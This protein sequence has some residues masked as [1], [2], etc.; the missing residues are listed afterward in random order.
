MPC[1][2]A[3]AGFSYTGLMSDFASSD[4]LDMMLE[5]LGLTELS[6]MSGYRK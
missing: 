1:A 3:G 5:I 2:G 4:G 6:R